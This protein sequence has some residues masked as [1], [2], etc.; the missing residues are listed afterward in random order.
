MLLG[1]I[2]SDQVDPLA[3]RVE[4]V[5]EKNHTRILFIE[6]FKGFELVV[7]HLTERYDEAITGA[8]FR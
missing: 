7:G 3:Y 8:Y 4:E 6:L 1:K 5:A 2:Q